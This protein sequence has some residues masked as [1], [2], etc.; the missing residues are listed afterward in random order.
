M[1]KFSNLNI[2]STKREPN[3]QWPLTATIGL[4]FWSEVGSPI[5]MTSQWPQTASF[6]G[7]FWY[8]PFFLI[9]VVL[10]WSKRGE[11]NASFQEKGN[12]I[13]LSLRILSF[14]SIDQIPWTLIK[15]K[16]TCHFF[17]C[18]QIITRYHSLI[19]HQLIMRHSPLYR[20]GRET[21]SRFP[22]TVNCCIDGSPLA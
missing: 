8:I 19:F 16:V 22:S 5:P 21:Y 7:C 9:W 10:V 3:P 20:L 1:N 2:C 13:P 17:Y 15:N 4:N 11:P 18:V 12:P 14:T 6:F